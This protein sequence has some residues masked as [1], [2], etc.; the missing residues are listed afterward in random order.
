M[1]QKMPAFVATAPPTTVAPTTP[2]PEKTTEPKVGEVTEVTETEEREEKDRIHCDRH[3]TCPQSS[4]CC[5]MAAS[6]RWGC[7]PLPHAV[8]CPGG[9]HCCPQN[10]KC[11]EDRTSC[12]K[13]H[14]EIPWYTKLPATTA[15]DDE[16]D[17]SAPQCDSNTRCPEHATCCQ[18][19]TGEWG[20]CPLR[21]AVCCPDRKHCC[22]GGYGCNLASH[23]CVKLQTLPLTAV[24]PPAPQPRPQPQPRPG[25]GRHRDIQCD[26]TTSCPDGDTCC[27]TSATTWG[28]CPIPNAVCCSDMTHCCP[29]GYTCTPEGNC[30]KKAGLQW[31]DWLMFLANRKTDVIV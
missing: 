11:N 6:Q 26:A 22:P 27:K 17:P 25:P 8:C 15:S 3:T 23:T 12:V 7:C 13:G 1:K 30:Q 24:D 21:H 31:H 20:C 10:Y 14:V 19:E 18:L 9:V 5:F 2:S 29:T 28:C 4:T 16:A